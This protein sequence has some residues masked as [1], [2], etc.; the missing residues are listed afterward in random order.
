MALHQKLGGAPMET[1]RFRDRLG[2]EKK[3]R[4]SAVAG[5]GGK[6]VHLAALLV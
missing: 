4:P 1:L 2:M 5:G 3:A 6:V